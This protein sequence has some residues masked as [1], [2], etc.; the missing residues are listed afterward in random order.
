MPPSSSSVFLPVNGQVSE[1]RSPPLSLVKM[2][3]V[4]SAMPFASQRFQHA[5]DLQ[6]HGLDHRRRFSASR[7]RNRRVRA[8]EPL[9]SASS[10]GPSHGQC[11]AL[12]CRLREMG[13]L[14]CA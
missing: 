11:G 5:A 2:T 13:C 14:A 8:D 3:M 7:R 1:K 6:V 10:P 9:D 12:K 4:L